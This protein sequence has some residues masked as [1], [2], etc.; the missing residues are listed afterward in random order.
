MRKKKCERERVKE[1]AKRVCE[2]ERDN[3]KAK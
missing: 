1:K 3:E 2:R